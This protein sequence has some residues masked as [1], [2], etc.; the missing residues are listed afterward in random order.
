MHQRATELR[1][2]RSTYLRRL[3]AALRPFERLGTVLQRMVQSGARWNGLFHLRKR[4]M[5]MPFAAPGTTEMKVIEFRGSDGQILRNGVFST[6]L[7][8][9]PEGSLFPIT[10]DNQ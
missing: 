10:W 3:Q 6:Y 7:V 8:A 1:S 9:M 2:C 5:P 4:A